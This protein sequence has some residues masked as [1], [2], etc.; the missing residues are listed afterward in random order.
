[1]TRGTT[2]TITFSFGDDVD[3]S[4]INY[5]EVTFNQNGKNVIIKKLAKDTVEKVFRVFLSETETLLFKPGK[6]NVQVKLKLKDGGIAASSI[7][8]LT[9]NEILNGGVML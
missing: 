9:V 4:L 1:M 8:I 6:C 7:E 5:G 3:M 2:P